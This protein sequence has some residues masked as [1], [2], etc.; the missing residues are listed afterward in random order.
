MVK[1]KRAIQKETL[2][3]ATPVDLAI[4]YRQPDSFTCKDYISFLLP[5]I[6]H[7]SSVP[8]WPADVFGI[9]MC[10]LLKSG[11]YVEA[12]SHWPPA[13]RS[14]GNWA[15]FAR[16]LGEEWRAGYFGGLVPAEVT[17]AWNKLLHYE[18]VG[19]SEIQRYPALCQ[20]LV[21]LCAI[22]D[23][24]CEGVG[25]PLD[26]GVR[27]K[28]SEQ[29]FYNFADGL[30]SE[31]GYGSSLGVEVPALKA[32][33]LPKMHTPQN[34]LTVRSLSHHLALCMAT[35]IKA[36]WI[37]TPEKRV[38]QDS[39]NVLVIPWPLDMMPSQFR[40]TEP[41]RSEMRNMPRHRFGFFTVESRNNPKIL[42]KH[43]KDLFAVAE[44][45]LG[46][47]DWVV[48]PEAALTPEDYAALK[49][50]LASKKCVLISGIGG[51]STPDKRGEN[52]I[53]IDIPLL[54]TLTQRKHHRWKL[55][56][57]QIKQYGLGSRLNT[58]R[59]WWEHIDLADR[60][61]MFL[62]LRPWLV[63]SVLVCEDLARPDPVGD[64]VRAVGPNLVLA[65]LMDGPQ[66]KDRWGARYATTL[67]DDPGCSVLT[68]TSTG[69]S[70]LSQPASGLSRSRVVALWKDA[71]SGA[72]KEI[73]LEAGADALALSLSVHYREEWSA[74]GRTDDESTSY[75]ILSGIHPITKVIL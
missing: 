43:I 15:K 47:V 75:V 49:K 69:M 30:L 9:C 20:N 51:A 68:V 66:L 50:S 4:Q 39:L 38:S 3:S 60:E 7:D 8:A 24:A 10:M 36:R 65:L 70:R 32:R 19:I 63:M 44:Q 40:E 29:K 28:N 6:R 18:S 42:I 23:E 21:Q 59:A 11:A 48:L 52:R 67:A 22:A 64:L 2:K 12:L 31:E 58:E 14:A 13:G 37:L 53:D 74:D 1:A 35:D 73:E 62:S 5:R 26:Q 56:F 27:I 41:L 72:P 54:E 25:I 33:V 45:R 16:G 46:S 34:G 71:L 61:L 55:D 57:S 17:T